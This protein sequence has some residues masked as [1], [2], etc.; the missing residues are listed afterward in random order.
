MTSAQ[1]QEWEE[2][3]E[4]TKQ[5]PPS[6]LLVKALA[7]VRHNGKAI[8]IGGGALKDTRFLLEKGFEVTVIDNEELMAKEAQKIRSV[9]LQYFVSSFADFDFPKNEY[10]VATAQYAL[11]FNPPD[12]FD[13]VFSCIKQSLVQGGILCGQFFGDRDEWH[14][15]PEMTFHTKEQVEQLL[16]DVEV[17][18][19]DEEEKDGH[20]ANGTPKHWHIFHFIARKR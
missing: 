20:I 2:Y 1:K 13:V 5:K 8:D 18:L 9:K 6:S 19:L 4:L 12:S 11:P 3:Y 16:S 14:T 15:N 7:S 10:D 17:I